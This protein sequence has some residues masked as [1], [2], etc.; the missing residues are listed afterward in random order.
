MLP[1]LRAAAS[2]TTLVLLA[3]CAG[4]GN[5]AGGSSVPRGP[6]AVHATRTAQ[7]VVSLGH[8]NVDWTNVVVA[9]ISSGADMASQLHYAHSSQIKGEAIFA[10]APFF[11]AQ[12]N[13][14]IAIDDC[15]YTYGPISLSTLETDT[16]NAAAEGYLDPVADLKG[17]KAWIFSGT[18]D[19]V[20]AQSVVKD[21]NT[22]LQHYSVTTT[23]NFTTAAE[24]GWVTP[25]VSSACGSLNSN[26]LINCGFDAEQQFLT[27]FF[28]TLS[29]RNS[30][31]LK[32]QLI[33]Y[34]QT[35]YA[36]AGLDSTGWIFVPSNC[37]SG[38]KCKMVVALHGCEQGQYWIGTTFVKDSGL[39]EWADTNSIIVLY[40][41]AVPSAGN[42]LGCW[43]WWGFD[44]SDYAS[45]PGLELNAIWKMM[46]QV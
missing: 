7:S 40:P 27:T 44:G 45:K 29:A 33:Q 31:T 1:M 4:G 28:G 38:S 15:E 16:N 2:C 3:A 5:G 19:T 36:V 20:V 23:T 6:G 46:Q 10:G 22:M 9:G 13:A 12:D 35:P 21:A 17:E 30:G 24:H 43:D 32:G 39:N 14:T 41:Q 26:Y 25:D 8:Y 34:S 18:A 11:C 42:S 37:A